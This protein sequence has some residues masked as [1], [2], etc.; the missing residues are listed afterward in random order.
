M[1]PKNLTFLILILLF[2]KISA[3]D[4]PGKINME[5]A[6]K[7]IKEYEITA[8][9]ESYDLDLV[10]IHEEVQKNQLTQ[11]TYFRDVYYINTVAG[12]NKIQSYSTDLSPDF[13]TFYLHGVTITRNGKEIQL[14]HNL[15]TEFYYNNR[16]IGG[17]YYRGVS[18]VY[19]YMEELKVGDI[20]EIEFT[21]K[22]F[23]PDMH[24]KILATDYIDNKKLLGKNIYR[25]LTYKGKTITY[26]PINIDVNPTF[27]Q[28][29]DYNEFENIV[30]QTEI[31]PAIEDPSWVEKDRVICQTDNEDWSDLVALFIENHKLD[32]KP[33][34][35]LVD[36]VTE[37]TQKITDK[38]KQAKAILDF[39]QGEIR[40]L[41]YGLLEPKRP[42]T[43][44]KHGFGDCKSK[45][46]LAIKMLETIGVKAWPVSVNS[47]GLDDRYL[48]SYG[49][50]FNH[51]IMEF[52]LAKDT[53]FYDATTAQNYG[54]IRESNVDDYRYGLR[55]LEG[56]NALS[57]I[58]HKRNSKIV[59]A[60]EINPYEGDF[61]IDFNL[62]RTVE[63]YGDLANKAIYTYKKNGIKKVK[64]NY[65]MPQY[66]QDACRLNS[67]D[68]NIKQSFEY[69]ENEG[70]AI[71]K[72]ELLSCGEWLDSNA[73]MMKFTPEPLHQWLTLE[74]NGTTYFNLPDFEELEFHYKI[75]E[76]N[77][78]GFKADTFQL[79]NDWIDYS[80]LTY[81]KGDTI[82]AQ[83]KAKFLVDYLPVSRYEEVHDD[84]LSIQDG[85]D[86]FNMSSDNTNNISLDN[87]PSSVKR[88]KIIS[89]I[90]LILII[91]TVIIIMLVLI[92]GFK[93]RKKLRARVT[94]LE[95]E[96]RTLQQQLHENILI[97]TDDKGSNEKVTDS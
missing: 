5:P 37:L 14:N 30:I 19:I 93:K 24:G 69:F 60:I 43:V 10:K 26:T 90:I 25:I 67:G 54:D 6:P 27:Y 28:G 2:S 50:P 68:S 40:Y 95:Q 71:L 11:E 75:F 55:V 49:Q 62:M 91:V 87:Y 57:V 65:F 41:D 13:E 58:K 31:P 94:I 76:P 35:L 32:E 78:I 15:H 51:E 73:S 20:I 77:D 36:K 82:F 48:Q 9:R 52:V 8:L 74:E 7:W 81:K 38:E 83:Y 34:K 17:E 61:S 22:G 80:K 59:A 44:L 66:G 16:Q 84:L 46:L 21:E 18:S 4:F 42:E 96:N 56:T 72:E 89:W 88:F 45:T 12:L 92:R 63:F 3:Q 85:L 39:V 64:E 86:V 97:K 1:F 79:Q 70:R 23:Q 33:Q 47:N 53:L 29:K